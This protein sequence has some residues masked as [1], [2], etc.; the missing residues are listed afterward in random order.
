M[1]TLFALIVVL[2]ISSSDS[3]GAVAWQ[4]TLIDTSVNALVD[5]EFGDFPTYSSY[6]VMD[7]VTD[8]AGWQLEAVTTYFTNAGGTFES[9]VNQG[10]LS[11]F[12]KTGAL[13]TAADNPQ[14][15]A[16][17]PIT[18][19]NMGDYYAIRADDLTL[20]LAGSTE[21]WIGLTPIADFG[22]FGQE[23]HCAAAPL[24]GAD[25]AWRNPGGSFGA[26]SHWQTLAGLDSTNTWVGNF[27]AAFMVE[28]WYFP[29]PAG[30]LLLCLGGIALPRRR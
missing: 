18:V 13:P 11:I 20:D 14:A 9:G 27:D 25:T 10:R 23:F 28:V 6:M 16:I 3:A 26:G 8:S 17:V 7:V 24:V 4:Q 2:L 15:E 21:Y 19:T 29:E 5:Q 1:R 22:T 30:I 12:E